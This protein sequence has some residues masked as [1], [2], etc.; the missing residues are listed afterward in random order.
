MWLLNWWPYA[1]EHR[2]N[3]IITHSV[4][5]P[6]GFNLAWTTSMP[7]TALVAVPATTAFGPIV[8]YNILCIGALAIAAWSA[9]LLCRRITADYIAAV[10]GGYLFG[11]SSYMLA[12]SRGHLPLILVFPAPLA[13][14]LVVNGLD[15]RISSA[16]FSLLLGAVLIT[17][18]LCWAELYATMA[19]FGAVALGLG[20]F[21][22]ERA[23]RERIRQLLVPIM[24]AY[25]VSLTVVLP[26]LYYF[27]RPGYPRSPINSPHTYSADLLNLLLPT[28]VNAL[29]DISL[30]ESVARRFT[31]NSLEASAYLGLPL[32]AI[33]IWFAW[34]RWQDPVTRLLAVFLVTVFTLMLGPR[35]RVN[36]NELFGMPWKIALHVPL[37]RDALP[38]RFSF[39]AFLALAIIVSMWL[40]APRPAGLKLAAIALLGISLCPNLH[41][42][43]WRTNNETPEFFISG[44]Y[45]RYVKPGENVLLL[46]YGINGGSML[47]QAAAGFYFRMA[48]G[49]TS[50]MP[51]E[52]QGWPIVGAMLTRTYIPDATSQLRAFMAAHDVRTILVAD[53]ESQFWQPMLAALDRSPIRVGG[54]VI[55]SIS[56][57][58]LAGSR[59]VSA[60]EMEERS[61][62]ARFS[63]LLFAAREYLAKTGDLAQLTP[64]RAQQMGLLPPHWVTDPDVRTNNGLY[65]GPWATNEVAVGVV[66]SYQ[67]LQ[68]LVRK[69]RATAAQIYFPFPKK[70]IEPPQGDTFMRLLVMV[71]ERNSLTQAAQVAESV[72]NSS[73]SLGH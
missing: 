54:L 59:A 9:F 63:A 6:V 73:T 43:F 1:I 46:P 27:F 48:E 13:V 37:L 39:Y 32:V 44:D 55:Y 15:G 66:G 50:I 45:H 18:L 49:W 38:V 11:F 4:W 31:G 60:M 52:F 25:A 72:Q 41:S 16:R 17:A 68:P 26:Y 64:M 14:L 35:L 19:L 34:S 61:N 65:L 30:I 23:V 56:P 20:L 69:Y 2:L 24:T 8:A 62:L 58:D 5:A 57:G 33:A 53:R 3:P 42:S 71:F 70:L 67:G 40:S 29:G 47:W 28:P 10:V 22:G 21:Y 7:L 36:G 51:R 12:E